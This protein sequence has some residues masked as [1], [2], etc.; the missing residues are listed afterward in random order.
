MNAAKLNVGSL[1]DSTKASFYSFFCRRQFKADVTAVWLNAIYFLLEDII[2]KSESK[3]NSMSQ[4]SPNPI[5][6]SQKFESNVEPWI[7][8]RAVNK[9]L[10]YWPQH[11]QLI[12]GQ[13]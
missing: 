3:P 8:T 13:S 12:E 4:L 10:F 7:W 5:P 9:V 6:I 2:D 1:L 11:H